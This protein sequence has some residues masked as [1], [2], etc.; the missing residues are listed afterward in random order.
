[1][2]GYGTALNEPGLLGIAEQL[3]LPYVQRQ[4]AGPSRVGA[5][6]RTPARNSRRQP[7]PPT[8]V[9]DRMELYWFFTLLASVLL[10]LS[11]T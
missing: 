9:A 7:A 1:M 3:G 8:G 10:L 6:A 5:D 2:L 4:A 11:S